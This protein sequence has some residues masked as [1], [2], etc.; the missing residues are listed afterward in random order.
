MI[1]IYDTSVIYNI[2]IYIYIYIQIII[3]DSGLAF[4]TEFFVI[5]SLFTPR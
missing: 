1:V 4:T 5:I 3:C 2:Y